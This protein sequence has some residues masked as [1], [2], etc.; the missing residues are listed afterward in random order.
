MILVV[1]VRYTRARENGLP[2]E[3]GTKMLISFSAL[4]LVTRLRESPLSRARVYCA[5][6]A[7][8]KDYSQFNTEAGKPTFKYWLRC[9]LLSSR[10]QDLSKPG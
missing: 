1:P 2:W 7:K 4:P 6:I 5:G 3:E 10:F 8:C 9:Q